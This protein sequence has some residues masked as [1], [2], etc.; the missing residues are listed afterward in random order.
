MQ[1][2]DIG[3]VLVPEKQ[4]SSTR[5]KKERYKLQKSDIGFGKL[6]PKS[7]H[8]A[9]TSV[10]VP[11]GGFLVKNT[12]LN[13]RSQNS[14]HSDVYSAI[15]QLSQAYQ[16]FN[17]MSVYQQQ[18]LFVGSQRCHTTSK[19][20]RDRSSIQSQQRFRQL[21]NQ[22]GQAQQDNDSDYLKIISFLNMLTV[23]G[24]LSPKDYMRFVD[25]FAMIQQSSHLTVQQKVEEKNELLQ[26]LIEKMDEIKK[27][28][29]SSNYPQ[30]IQSSQYRIEESIEASD[31]DVKMASI[32][33]TPKQKNSPGHQLFFNEIVRIHQSPQRNAPNI[34]HGRSKENSQFIP[35]RDSDACSST[36]QE[37]KIRNRIFTTDHAEGSQKQSENAS[38]SFFN[39]PKSL[40]ITNLNLSQNYGLIPSSPR[41]Q[42]SSRRQIQTIYN[43]D[44]Q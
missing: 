27:P 17:N 35:D 11:P 18:R 13:L 8:T 5:L 34:N 16:K 10:H 21:K 9:Q 4:S 7:P 19:T 24:F 26:E 30:T 2:D 1:N 12:P 32:V 44:R 25:A 22:T 33:A 28:L 31:A 20:F 15:R 40:N 39:N 29:M 23:Q 37:A 14:Y 38:T 3:D 42:P 6:L 41:V 43:L 36:M